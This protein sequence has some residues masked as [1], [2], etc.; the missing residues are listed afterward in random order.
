MLLERQRLQTRGH[1]VLLIIK[2]SVYEK[3][4]ATLVM[5]I[6]QSTNSGDA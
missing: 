5:V 3:Y 4:E 2:Q 1:Y 6:K